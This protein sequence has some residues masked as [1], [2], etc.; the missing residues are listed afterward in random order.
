MNRSPS[1]IRWVYET[2]FF[3]KKIMLAMVWTNYVTRVLP[4][5]SVSVSKSNKEQKKT[6]LSQQDTYRCVFFRDI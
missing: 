5:T 1:Y 2:T 6:C 3:N 4:L